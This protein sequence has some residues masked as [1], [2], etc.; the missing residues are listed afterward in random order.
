M[1]GFKEY[2]NLILSIL[3]LSATLLLLIVCVLGWYVTNKQAYVT[4]VVGSTKD[5]NDFSLVLEYYDGQAWEEVTDFDFEDMYPGDVIT[6][7]LNVTCNG[8][9]TTNISTSFTGI[10]SKSHT[11][12]VDNGYV[13]LGD[14][15]LYEID[16]NNKV[17]VNDED[18]LYLISNNEISL[19]DYKLEDACK[20]YYLE[21][22]LVASDDDT[23]PLIS[24]NVTSNSII[25]EFISSVEITESSNLYF[26]IKYEDLETNNYYAYQTLD[27]DQ[28]IVSYK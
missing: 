19:V 4:G 20:V 21:K 3:S 10:T 17:T 22:R 23:I 9:A 2:K 12:T 1:K 11:L 18:T 5:N 7:R 24:N 25:D 13:K 14:V 27:I 26:A 6:F 16:E 15:S 28:L 8:T